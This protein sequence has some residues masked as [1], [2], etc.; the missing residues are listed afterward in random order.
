MSLLKQILLSLLPEGSAWTVKQNADLDKLLDGIAT[1]KDNIKNILGQLANIRNPDLTPYNIATPPFEKINFDLLED[2]EDDYGLSQNK[3]LPEET[4]RASIK[5]SKISRITGGTAED[6]QAA[7]RTADY[8]VYVYPNDPA[9]DPRIFFDRFFSITCGNVD[10][11]CDDEKAF[12]ARRGGWLIIN[13]YT[14]LDQPKYDIDD[15][16]YWSLMFFVGGPATYGPLEELVDIQR[17][18][19]PL[20]R[21]AE[22]FEII[23]QHKP[24]YTWGVFIGQFF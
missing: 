14:V 16:N 23:L 11:N 17:V 7:L 24:I 3:D 13:D 21:K 4:R 8:D 22:F 20:E 1:D 15:P 9:V 5:S 6:M 19:I 12:C 10:A 18:N 2:L